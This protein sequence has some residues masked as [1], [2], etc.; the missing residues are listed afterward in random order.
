MIDFK[1]IK[2][3]HLIGVGG[4]GMSALAAFLIHDKKIVSGS[5]L[6]ENENTIKL[7]NLGA[8]II[9]GPHE[10]KNLPKNTEMVIFSSAVTPESPERLEATKNNIPQFD[11]HEALGML[12]AGSKNLIVTGTHGKTTTTAMLASIL[13]NTKFD[14][15]VL[16]GSNTTL[17]DG[18][19]RV[20]GENYYVLEGDEYKRG[21]EHLN[22]SVILLNNVE[23][24]HP[25][26]YPTESSYFR[27]FQDF[28][29]TLPSDGLFVCNAD[30]R[31]IS[32]KFEMP[33]CR[34]SK[35]G[36]KNT[37]ADLV[38]KNI[39]IAHSRQIFKLI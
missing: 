35:F 28:V 5:D 23:W 31:L 38:A 10:A 24:D 8:K 14:P 4:I 22:P 18:N 13:I 16:V 39:K 32:D 17:L 2:K 11:Y 19:Y 20:G 3:V 6:F 1:K 37:Q 26:V 29:N 15:N 30:D 34:V 33:S 12:T 25:D 36:I 27:M 9:Y 7:I 21:V